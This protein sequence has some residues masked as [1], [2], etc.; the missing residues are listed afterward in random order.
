[1]AQRYIEMTY[2]DASKETDNKLRWDTT[3]EDTVFSLYIPKWRVPEPWPRTIGLCVS[4]RRQ[5]SLDLPNLS[6]ADVQEDPASRLEPLVATVQ[7]LREHT[8][9]LR[10]DPV[11]D[12]SDWEVGNPYVPHSLTFGECRR[13]RLI[14]LWD[15]ATR[16]EFHSAS[17]TRESIRALD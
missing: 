17:V 2:F 1:M 14:V 4:P 8:K 3:I 12:P 10:Y 11:G 5:E 16:G 6:P 7:F 13:L 15:L 9:T